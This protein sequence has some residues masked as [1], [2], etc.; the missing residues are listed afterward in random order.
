VVS[1]DESPVQ[2]IGELREPVAAVPRQAERY[3]S[4]YRRNGTA[5]L[6]VMVD[7]PA[8]MGGM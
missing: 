5:N 4:G 6:F 1:F 8:A 3:D 2:L 7:A